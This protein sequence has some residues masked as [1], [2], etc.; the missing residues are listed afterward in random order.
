MQKI[1]TSWQILIILGFWDK[2]FLIRDFEFL[3]VSSEIKAWTHHY[4]P[5]IT[6]KK[7]ISTSLL[8]KLCNSVQAFTTNKISTSKKLYL[9]YKTLQEISSWGLRATV[10]TINEILSER[11]LLFFYVRHLVVVEAKKTCFIRLK[12]VYIFK[13]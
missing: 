5:D 2:N 8:E 4:L 11:I 6:V 9:M 1:I 3:K 7:E 13:E 12:L 10:F